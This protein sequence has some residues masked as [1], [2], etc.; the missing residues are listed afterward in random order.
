[1]KLEPRP[2]EWHEMVSE[3]LGRAAVILVAYLFVTPFL[4]AV[5]YGLAG[6]VRALA[7]GALDV[8]AEDDGVPVLKSQ[9]GLRSAYRECQVMGGTVHAVPR[10]GAA[11]AEV[12]ALVDE[13]LHGHAQRGIARV[14]PVARA[15]GGRADQ[16]LEAE[17]GVDSI[18]RIEI[19]SGL[20]SRLPATLGARFRERMDQLMQVKTVQY[21][22]G[23][24]GPRS[25]VTGAVFGGSAALLVGLVIYVLGVFTLPL[26]AGLFNHSLFCVVVGAVLGALVGTSLSTAK[27]RKSPQEKLPHMRQPNSEGYLVA[28]KM[29]PPFAERAEEIARGLGAKEI[30]L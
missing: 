9:L 14:G 16:D 7:K 28:V 15:S 1:M 18:K 12:E 3:T 6:L 4:A 20:E 19:L 5:M 23:T 10:A 22:L 24:R 13:L 2:R 29:P 21:G 8:M 17:L 25:A 11:V 27:Q 30:L 26:I